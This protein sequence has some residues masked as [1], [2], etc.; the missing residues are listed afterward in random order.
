[1]T[2]TAPVDPL[3]SDLDQIEVAINASKVDAETKGL[4]KELLEWNRGLVFRTVDL[5]GRTYAL[6]A[7]MDELLAG[8]EE[9][10]SPETAQ[11][12]MTAFEQSR[13]V[14]ATLMALLEREDN[15]FDDVN[16][17]RVAQIL[18]NARDAIQIGMQTVSEIVMV[19]DEDGDDG[20]DDGGDGGSDGSDDVG[21]GSG[22]R[23]A[24]D[25]DDEPEEEYDEEEDDEDA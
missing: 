16:S 13:I 6:E 5:S 25:S 23:D 8:V 11:I 7:G 21:D 2:T 10:I 14:C 9:L 22:G 3:R 4:L 24:E 1:M 18:Q 15:P 12:F 17:K 20:A 19:E